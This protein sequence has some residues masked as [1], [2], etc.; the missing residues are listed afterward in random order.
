MPFR[1]LLLMSGLFALALPLAGRAGAEE[2]ASVPDAAAEEGRP[3]DQGKKNRPETDRPEGGRRDGRRSGPEWLR[4]LPEEQRR[5]V[6]AAL[7]KIWEDED[8]KAARERLNTATH[9]YKRTVRAA[10]NEADPELAESVRPMLER[11]LRE[12]LPSHRGPAGGGGPGA[13]KARFFRL[14]GIFRSQLDTLSEGD[15]QL[16]ETLAGQVMSDPRVKAALARPEGD[17][18]PSGKARL[19]AIKT[20]RKTVKEIALER[21]PRLKELLETL[22]QAPP[23]PAGR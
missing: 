10:L 23:A 9:N 20:C 1:T 2:S 6:L 17:G 4:E 3:Q 8:V 15:R 22:C 14:L 21:E 13:E 12:S 16:L 11:I 19:E 5:Q 18:E 7:K